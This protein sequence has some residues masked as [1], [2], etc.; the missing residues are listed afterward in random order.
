MEWV[1]GAETS[2][3]AIESQDAEMVRQ[4][5][6]SLI[7]EN[8]RR[9]ESISKASAVIDAVHAE[10][11][12][13]RTKMKERDDVIEE[14]K[15][16]ERFLENKIL[17]LETERMNMAKLRTVETKLRSEI[18]GLKHEID[19]LSSDSL[20]TQ[21]ELRDKLAKT[22]KELKE[23]KETKDKIIAE[24]KEL[25][26]S[27][28]VSSNLVEDYINQ[29]RQIEDQ[30]TLLSDALNKLREEH[31]RVIELHKTEVAA[32]KEAALKQIE[33]VQ[34]ASSLG[35]GH[36]VLT[37][38]LNLQANAK[39]GNEPQV[40]AN[41]TLGY[42]SGQQVYRSG[43]GAEDAGVPGRMGP[44]GP[45]TS[46]LSN[47][48]QV[49]MLDA[50]HTVLETHGKFC[51][52]IDR[53][54]QEEAEEVGYMLESCEKTLQWMS[55][56]ELK[57]AEQKQLEAVCSMNEKLES[58]ILEQNDFISELTQANKQAAATIQE[59]IAE[60]D[61]QVANFSAAAQDCLEACRHQT[62]IVGQYGAQA[63]QKLR[64]ELK[65][66][67]EAVQD[68]SRQSGVASKGS[69]PQRVRNLTEELA[70]TEA[71]LQ[72]VRSERDELVVKLEELL[73]ELAQKNKDLDELADVIDRMERDMGDLKNCASGYE[74]K[75]LELEKLL[76]QSQSRAEEIETENRRLIQKC[77][78]LSLKSV[79]KASKDPFYNQ[80][81]SGYKPAAHQRE[82][83][84][85]QLLIKQLKNEINE[86][87]FE[88]K[89]RDL[90]IENLRGEV[91]QKKASQSQLLEEHHSFRAHEKTLI[92]E[93][94]TLRAENRELSRALANASTSTLKHG[95]LE[96][97]EAYD[98]EESFK[99]MTTKSRPQRTAAYQPLA[100]QHHSR[101]NQSRE[102]ADY[103]YGSRERTDPRSAA[104]TH[105]NS[106]GFSN[107]LYDTNP[108][109]F[110]DRYRT[111]QFEPVSSDHSYSNKLND[112]RLDQHRI[113]NDY[114]RQ[115]NVRSSLEGSFGGQQSVRG[116]KDHLS[117]KKPM[118]DGYYSGAEQIV[119]G[120][121][122]DIARPHPVQEHPANPQTRQPARRGRE[123]L[124]D[125]TDE[126][127]DEFERELMTN[128]AFD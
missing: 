33:V 21:A 68:A 73:A 32:I 81:A 124:E 127:L 57:S 114:R 76:K 112:S 4:T 105:Q 20:E 101:L 72:G 1:S 108:R 116:S 2:P 106:A 51:Q 31:T 100:Q 87:K 97:T 75:A 25:S 29:L 16:Q 38:N 77:E 18:E 39:K 36:T 99:T 121:G 50:L 13:L 70:E 67:E 65:G 24:I 45:Q 126:D 12:T 115:V 14:L 19:L 93:V 54:A 91:E 103:R 119:R 78:D 83:E 113:E 56:R 22:Q 58:T 85:S 7:R 88:V 49:L 69:L 95:E 89:E 61:R 23:E 66:V 107:V 128:S 120:T 17:S 55:S 109:H 111:G 60:R 79:Q 102:Y 42:Q 53:F 52:H 48:K 35:V 46:Q 110:V 11:K 118:Q 30:N 90:E 26:N 96:D 15:R 8:R 34:A 63:A 3:A 104:P 64:E 62:H 43:Q 98:H 84:E 44:Y 9:D 37:K 82:K 71:E 80:E 94:S 10:N 6:E 59:L 41:R 74:K 28:K 92:K 86:L 5:I 40:T 122:H 123:V 125:I 117:F 27:E 47:A